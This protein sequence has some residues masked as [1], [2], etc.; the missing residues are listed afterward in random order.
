MPDALVVSKLYKPMAALNRS[1]LS[2]S[3]Y[4]IS[5]APDWR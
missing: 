1:A 3:G 5:L 2:F 4:R